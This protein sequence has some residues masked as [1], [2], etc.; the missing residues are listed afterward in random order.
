MTTERERC[1]RGPERV[2]GP[3]CACD[4]VCLTVAG[5]ASL[6]MSFGRRMEVKPSHLG[7]DL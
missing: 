7:E 3:V 4:R 6:G 5:L 1:A 2:C